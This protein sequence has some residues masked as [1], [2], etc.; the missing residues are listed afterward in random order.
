M[1]ILLPSIYCTNNTQ[2]YKETIKTFIYTSDKVYEKV[3]Q[4]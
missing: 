3:T 4:R 2:M 1:K